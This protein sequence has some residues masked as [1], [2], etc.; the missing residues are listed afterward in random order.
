MSYD[1]FNEELA[2]LRIAELWARWEPSKGPSP[3]S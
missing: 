2:R 3:D 1:V